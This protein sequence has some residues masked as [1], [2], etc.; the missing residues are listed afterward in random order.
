MRT[1]DERRIPVPAERRLSRSGLGH[2]AHA[3][4]GDAVVA[5]QNA[6]LQFD[7]DGVRI[8]RVNLGAEAVSSVS[9]RPIRID[10]AGGPARSRSPADP[11]IFLPPA[12]HPLQPRATIHLHI[13]Y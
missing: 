13:I 10:D 4:A 11:A 12:I 7:V 9:E 5:D 8:F 2:D 1:D 6:I 3:F